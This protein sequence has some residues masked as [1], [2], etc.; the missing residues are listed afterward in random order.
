MCYSGETWARLKLPDR[1]KG[2]QMK[3]EEGTVFT[4]PLRG[5]SV[6]AM[7]L[8][9]TDPKGSTPK[10]YLCTDEFFLRMLP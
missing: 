6:A 7:A 4:V 2:R 1:V 3:N 5:V 10:S 9:A 8:V